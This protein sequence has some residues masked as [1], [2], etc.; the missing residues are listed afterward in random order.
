MLGGVSLLGR[1]V[2]LR[3]VVNALD[4]QGRC[5]ISGPGGVGKTAL[6]RAVVERLGSAARASD[7]RV[8]WVDV[9]P[10]ASLDMVLLAVLRSCD[11]AL[12]PGDDAAA[13]VASVLSDVVGVVVLD[14]IEH[15]AVDL[16]PVL[17]T[18]PIAATGARLLVTSRD[19]SGAGILPVVRLRPFATTPGTGTP[20]LEILVENVRVRGGDIRELLDDQHRVNA[21]LVATGGLPLAIELSAARI[22]RFGLAAADEELLVSTGVMDRCVRRSLDLV[23]ASS[24]RSMHSLALAAGPLSLA[25]VTLIAGAG[26]HIEVQLGPLLDHGLVVSIKDRYIVPYPIRE[27][28]LRHAI[29]VASLDDVLLQTLDRLA[30]AA[31]VSDPNLTDHVDEVLGI[32]WYATTRPL[33]RQAATACA[34][35]L[36]DVMTHAQRHR[37]LLALL[38]ATLSGRSSDPDGAQI[39]AVMRAAICASECES[40]ASGQAWLDRA[41]TMLDRLAT[42]DPNLECGWWGLRSAFLHDGGDLCAAEIA[43]TRAIEVGRSHADPFNHHQAVRLLAE[44]LVAQGRL[45]EADDTLAAAA[46]W[47]RLNDP[48]SAIACDLVRGRVLL[49]RGRHGEAAALGV[50]SG[51]AAAADPNPPTDFVID[52]L[53]LQGTIAP[54]EGPDPGLPPVDIWP[55]PLRLR[56]RLADAGSDRD[57]ARAQ[58][59]AI[60]VSVLAGVVGLREI[61]IVADTTIGDA[62]LALGDLPQAWA[63]YTRALEAAA[64]LGFRLR[65][66][67]AVTGLAAVAAAGRSARASA[68]EA[69]ATTIRKWCG[70][71]QRPR[72]LLPATAPGS[73][74]SPA[75]WLVDALP[76]PEGVAVMVDAARP[77]GRPT[78]SLSLSRAEQEVAALVAEGLTNQQIATALFVSRR[79]VESH[80]VHIFRKLGIRTRTQLAAM[81]FRA[82]SGNDEGGAPSR[83]S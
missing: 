1:E 80:L 48:Y 71:A 81:Q 21:V 14:G 37:D 44:V 58:R 78:H 70:A 73:L 36:F 9:E 46:A 64:R 43:A 25:M 75:G 15:L 42:P 79:T 67:D 19:P 38:I 20:A 49:E 54:Q 32:V 60:D 31:T 41:R 56:W 35:A 27:A 83:Y 76:T 6:A 63:A 39:K 57:A 8:I 82:Q 18:W 34:S 10:C 22:A 28:I 55:W 51:Q 12:H 33:A 29:D 7:R 23:G 59:V 24:V 26:D 61:T 40:V 16:Q 52:A 74:A 69:A 65:A 11:A 68:L 13:A 4:A 3:D 2:E 30:T 17:A 62:S 47:A 45:D 53:L 72:T 50:L 66:A 77:T 5:L